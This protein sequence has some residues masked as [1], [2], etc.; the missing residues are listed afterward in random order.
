LNEW[1][2][3]YHTVSGPPGP[4]GDTGATG[5]T[6]HRGPSGRYGPAGYHGPRGPVG[7]P[8]LPGPAA[9]GSR[10][11]PGP[12]GPIGL[13]GHIGIPGHAGV[14]GIPTTYPTLANQNEY[15]GKD[16]TRRAI[17]LQGFFYVHSEADNNNLSP[18]LK[19]FPMGFFGCRHIMGRLYPSVSRNIS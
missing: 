8:G 5:A 15:T 17:W 12:T 18:A 16:E 11:L 10:G 19:N 4:P 9:P 14:R 13:R 2:Y 7:P 1:Q 6:G 3:D